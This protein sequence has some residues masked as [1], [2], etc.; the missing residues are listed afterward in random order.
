MIVY[1]S[2]ET[3]LHST[4]PLSYNFPRES[5]YIPEACYLHSRST[6]LVMQYVKFSGLAYETSYSGVNNNSLE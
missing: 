6:S 4:L 3:R 2:P 1:S 5:M